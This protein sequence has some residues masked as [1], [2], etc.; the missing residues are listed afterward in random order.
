MKKCLN[1][2]LADL[3]DLM[4]HHRNPSITKIKMLHHNHC[5]NYGLDR[6]MDFMDLKSVPSKNLCYRSN[7]R[8]SVIQTTISENFKALAI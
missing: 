5:L 3:Y 2:D 4:I 1:H 8:K 7:P 6:L